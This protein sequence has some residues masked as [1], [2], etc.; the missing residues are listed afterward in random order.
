MGTCACMP[1]TFLER[2]VQIRFGNL[3]C[4][5]EP[6]YQATQ[7]RQA[8]R[9]RQYRKINAKTIPTG[10][11]LSR[12]SGIGSPEQIDSPECNQNSECSTN[13]GDDDA[14][15]QQLPNNAPATGA[16]RRPH[17]DLFLTAAGAR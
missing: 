6:E 8:K 15:D 14:F 13:Q 17:R 2:V 12:F 7:Q 11:K 3:P 4:R 1:S 5:S 10:S 9:K 16:H